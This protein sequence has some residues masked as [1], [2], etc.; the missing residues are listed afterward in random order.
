MQCNVQWRA[1]ALA[2]AGL[3][4]VTPLVSLAADFTTTTAGGSNSLGYTSEYFVH[5]QTNAT[6]TA[7]SLASQ[8]TL[9]AAASNSYTFYTYDSSGNIIG[10]SPR[11]DSTSASYSGTVS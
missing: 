9:S 1:I 3:A 10:S 2:S 4:A 11:Y 5:D 7:G 8:L 6:P